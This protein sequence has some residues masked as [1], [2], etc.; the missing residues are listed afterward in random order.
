MIA[1]LFVLLGLYYVV[2]KESR[3]QPERPR[4]VKR[5]LTVALVVT[6]AMYGY[7]HYSANRPPLIDYYR[8]GWFFQIQDINAYLSRL[9]SPNRIP[10]P[11][12][13]Q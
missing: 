1:I 12:G 6:M 10:I 13:W 2:Y 5:M 4:P 8:V 11:E 9:G 7:S 3:P